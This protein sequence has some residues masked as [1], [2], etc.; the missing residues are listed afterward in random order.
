MENNRTLS[1]NE[2]ITHIKNFNSACKRNQKRR[3][4]QYFICFSSIHHSLKWKRGHISVQFF[5]GKIWSM[6]VVITWEIKKSS[7]PSAWKSLGDTNCR[8][9]FQSRNYNKKTFTFSILKNDKDDS[10][11]IITVKH[12]PTMKMLPKQY[13]LNRVTHKNSVI[14]IMSNK[15]QTI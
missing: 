6:P 1:K 13:I 7:T 8:L 9:L 12:N 5:P 14:A 11:T 2:T 10:H 15:E 3:F 4:L